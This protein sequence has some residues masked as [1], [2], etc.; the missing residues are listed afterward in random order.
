VLSIG[1]MWLGTRLYYV[2]SKIYISN[3]IKHTV[4]RIWPIVDSAVK[5]SLI[6]ICVDNLFYGTKYN[7]ICLADSGFGGSVRGGGGDRKGMLT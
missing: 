5:F 7:Y 1:L 3:K 2:L 6:S 4:G